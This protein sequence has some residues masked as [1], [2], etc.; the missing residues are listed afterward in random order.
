MKKKLS[1]QK[2]IGKRIKLLRSEKSLTQE[3]LARKADIP[4]TTLTRLK[5]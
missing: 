2:T 4:Y 5:Y 1:N 3:G